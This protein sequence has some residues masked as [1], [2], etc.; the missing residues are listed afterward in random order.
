MLNIRVVSYG[1][2]TWSLILGS[3]MLRVYTGVPKVPGLS[4]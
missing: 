4:W 3:E 1:R 2:E